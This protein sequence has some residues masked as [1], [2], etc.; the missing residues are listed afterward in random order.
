MA[1]STRE[2]RKG[3]DPGTGF[4]WS[5][6]GRKVL[7]LHLLQ[8]EGRRGGSKGCELVGCFKR[9]L[10]YCLGHL[11]F[12]KTAPLGPGL[13]GLVPFPMISTPSPYPRPPKSEGACQGLL[14][15]WVCQDHFPPTILP[16]EEGPEV[17]PVSFVPV[18]QGEAPLCWSA[19]N[20]SLHFVPRT[21]LPLLSPSSTYGVHWK[22]WEHL[23]RL[24]SRGFRGQ[25]KA[26]EETAP[27]FAGKCRE[28]RLLDL[29]CGSPLPSHHPAPNSDSSPEAPTLVGRLRLTRL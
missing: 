23:S 26:S 7:I 28:G 4:R 10:T 29:S 24:L 8:A 1:L 20:R 9:K 13:G 11:K 14:A 17:S 6:D 18:P 12:L 22:A 3:R 21:R 25:L 2:P 16:G 5:C 15:L 19:S 27:E